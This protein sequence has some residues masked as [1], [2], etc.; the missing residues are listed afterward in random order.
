M[1][2]QL[3]TYKVSVSTGATLTWDVEAD[4]P[5]S[6]LAIAYVDSNDAAMAFESGTW[7]VEEYDQ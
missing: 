6:A 3:K 7:E 4:S 2:A 5:D 1:D